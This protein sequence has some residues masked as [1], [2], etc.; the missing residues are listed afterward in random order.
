M[1]DGLDKYYQR[2]ELKSRIEYYESQMPKP[3][4]SALVGFVLLMYVAIRTFWNWLNADQVRL[5]WFYA[6]VAVFAALII[7]WIVYA[8]KNRRTKAEKQFE[9]YLKLQKLFDEGKI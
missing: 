5:Y 8:I 4:R 3:K 6:G 9:Q 7:W 1:D 2:K